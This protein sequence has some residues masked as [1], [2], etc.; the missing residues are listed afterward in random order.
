MPIDAIIRVS[1]QSEVPANQAANK[2]LVGHQ[3]NATGNGPF[4]RLNT[5]AYVCYQ[6]PDADVHQSLHALFS[7]INTHSAVLDYLSVSMTRHQDEE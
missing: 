4:Q 2:A 1:F 5:A 7:A 3:S 6:A